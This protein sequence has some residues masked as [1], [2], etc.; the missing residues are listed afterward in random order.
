MNQAQNITMRSWLRETV[1]ERA[2][3]RQALF[4]FHGRVGR[5]MYWRF[6]VLPGLLFLALS[7]LFDLPARMGTFGFTVVG[8]LVGWIVLAIT[9]KRCHDR[10]R[11]GWF[12]LVGLIPVIGSLWLLFDLGGQPGLNENR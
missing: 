3:N 11:T 9:I 10:G 7:T 1:E 8:V 6:A 5:S 12:M 2:A 4:S